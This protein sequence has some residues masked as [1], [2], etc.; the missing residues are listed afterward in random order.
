M[1]RGLDTISF[2]AISAASSST[3]RGIGQ[4]SGTK[5][6]TVGDGGAVGVSEA[7]SSGRK[8]S[9]EDV[10]GLGS[11][12]SLPVGSADILKGRIFGAGQLTRCVGAK[13][14][15]VAWLRGENERVEC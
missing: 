2:A 14:W 10:M 5:G 12:L 13:K 7:P 8:S 1:T 3:V 11:G 9:L 6:E 15:P 4:A